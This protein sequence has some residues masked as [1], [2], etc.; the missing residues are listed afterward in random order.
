MIDSFEKLDLSPGMLDSLTR[1]GFSSPSPIQVLTIPHLLQGRDIIGQAQTGTGKTAAFGI[2]MLENLEPGVKTINTLVL[3]P[4]RELAIQVAQEISR[5]AA[6]LPAVHIVPIYGGQP[7]ERQFQLLKKGAQVVIGTPG[8][9]MDHM[10]RGTIRL[11]K[12][13]MVVLDEADEMLNMGFREDIESILSKAPEDCQRALFSATMPPAIMK[14]AGQFLHEPEILRV[15][16]KV[17]TVEAI[18][19]VYY[20]VRPAQKLDYLYRLL[21]S[22]DFHK[23]LVFCSTKHSVDEMAACLQSQGYQADCL[24]GNLAQTQRD[25]VMGRF[26]KGQIKIL[27]AT[28]VAARGLDV[29]DVDAVINY[30]IPNDAENY[31]HRI[32]RTGRA[33][34]NGQACTFV[35]S[36]DLY[37]LKDIMRRTKA[38]IKPAQ[39]PSVAQMI[40]LKTESFMNNLQNSMDNGELERYEALARQFQT[41][42]TPDNTTA[43]AALFK[44]LLEKDISQLEEQEAREA[45]TVPDRPRTDHKNTAFSRKMQRLHFNIGAKGGISPRDLVGAITGETGLPGSI[46]GAIEIHEMFSLV[47][48]E[49]SVINDVIAVMNRKLIRGAK[50]MVK[51][52]NK[53]FGKEG[54]RSHKNHNGR[55]ER[56]ASMA[57]YKPA[58]KPARAR[59]AA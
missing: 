47:D 46:I 1:M 22:Q 50:V 36:R 44:M 15:E 19:Q 54:T 55:F 35:S 40:K 21:S 49:Y 8:R 45:R 12:L 9:I 30:D 34:K 2:P 52:D 24:H 16:Q 25:K 43:L 11:D 41:E 5:L 51:T 38:H 58:R 28:D 23:A 29:N 6:H 37:K 59:Q 31:V 4:T 7:I 14:L 33:G 10:E 27:V 48:V 3:C 53:D 17:L 57:A 56:Q 42:F 32:G 20:E 39:I 13:D 26:R 18:D